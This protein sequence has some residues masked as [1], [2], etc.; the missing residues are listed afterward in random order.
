MQVP[1]YGSGFSPNN[2][3]P[4]PTIKNHKKSNPN[5]DDKIPIIKSN[6]TPMTQSVVSQSLVLLTTIA[7]DLRMKTK[8][9]KH[10][11]THFKSYICSVQETHFRKKKVG[12]HMTTI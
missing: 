8:S 4:Q 2:P 7:A 11:I 12:S 9:L 3:E 5:S 1:T 10:I 6:N